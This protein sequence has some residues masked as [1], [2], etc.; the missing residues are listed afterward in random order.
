MKRLVLCVAVCFVLMFAV[1]AW[2]QNASMAARFQKPVVG[3]TLGSIQGKF[4]SI[5]SDNNAGTTVT[6]YP[7]ETTV[8][9]TVVPHSYNSK[10][11]WLIVQVTLQESCPSDDIATVVYA[12]GLAMYPDDNASY[13]YECN[14]SSSYETHTRTWFF[15]P[16]NLGGPVIPKVV[17]T[18]EVKAVSSSGTASIA[19]RSVIVQAV[20]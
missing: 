8:A 17:S 19:L 13:H 15:P 1:S 5:Y 6:A 7:T 2:A 4:V 16:Q 20:K 11:Q 12:A 18:V 14:N 10:T 3:T 9:S